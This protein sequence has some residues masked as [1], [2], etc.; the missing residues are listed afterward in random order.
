MGFLM[1]LRYD[2][3]LSATGSTGVMK[4]YVTALYLG[5]MSSVSTDSQNLSSC[6]NFFLLGLAFVYG[7][8]FDGL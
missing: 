4:G 1:I 5:F 7:K 6:W 3:M 2:G 8:S